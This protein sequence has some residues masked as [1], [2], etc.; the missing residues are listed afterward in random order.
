MIADYFS[1]AVRRADPIPFIFLKLQQH[2]YSLRPAVLLES[3]TEPDSQLV[4]RLATNSSR[5]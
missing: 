1:T 2:A 5:A 3:G 4:E